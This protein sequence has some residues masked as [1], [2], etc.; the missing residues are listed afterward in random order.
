[1]L[2]ALMR[3]RHIAR[4]DA[5]LTQVSAAGRYAAADNEAIAR[6]AALLSPQRATDLL[7]QILRRNAATH[8]GACAK[9][10]RCCVEA[11]AGPVGEPEAIGAA[12]L[13]VLPGDPARAA[14][15]AMWRP[16][17]PVT[18]DLVRDLLTALSRVDGGVAMRAIDYL[19]AW[20]KVYSPDDVLIPAALA[21]AESPEAATWPAVARLPAACLAHLRAR[22]AEP[23]EAPRD[24]ARVNP[25]RCGCDDCRSLGRFLT[26]PDEREWR[27]KAVA[28]RRGHIEGNVRTTP[29]DLDLTTERR[30]SPHTLIARKNQAS[31][32]RRT[33][34][35]R[36][37]LRYISTLGG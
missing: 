2:D 37:D 10:L 31:H 26:D 13:D 22:V 25:L 8:I 16:S 18:P 19:L 11:E 12:L 28:A 20:P 35:R 34:Q 32:E 21:F 3:L 36:Q 1:M 23:L 6:A 29:C 30:G 15:P 9:L 4:I 14:A 7:V 33:A 27:L 17:E 24:W 5:F